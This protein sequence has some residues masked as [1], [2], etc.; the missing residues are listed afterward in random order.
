[1]AENNTEIKY[2]KDT[3]ILYLWKG[4]PSRAS[5][6]IGDFII[7]VDNRGYI[8]GMEILN[9]SENLN[10]DTNLLE[11]IGQASMSVIYKPNYIHII[12]KAKFN[13]KQKEISIPL[14]V[15]L[16]H[17]IIEKEMIVFGK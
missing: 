16:G 17:K 14:T 12:L 8:T 13:G 4:K 1:M 9:V 3:D 7:D 11:N 10:I 6:E 2:Y 15:D 5:I